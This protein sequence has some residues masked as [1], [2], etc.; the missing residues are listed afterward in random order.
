MIERLIDFENKPSIT[1]YLMK[2]KMDKPFENLSKVLEKYAREHHIVV[3]RYL[4]TIRILCQRGGTRNRQMSERVEERRR[5]QRKD[6]H[7]QITEPVYNI[8]VSTPCR[9]SVGAEYNPSRPNYFRA[10]PSPTGRSSLFLEH[11]QS[12]SV[13]FH[14]KQDSPKYLHIPK[15]Q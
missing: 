3:P 15:K 12:P 11:S 1:D 7:C 10:V 2:L 8:A 9:R 14:Y 6:S 4:S 13:S 5:S